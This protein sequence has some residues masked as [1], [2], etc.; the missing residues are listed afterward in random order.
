MRLICKNV[1]SQVQWLRW[2]S[3]RFDEIKIIKN[4]NIKDNDFFISL[5]TSPYIQAS[6][7][8]KKK[9]YSTLVTLTQSKKPNQNTKCE[10]FPRQR[11]TGIQ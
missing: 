2:K 5:I 1:Q 11:V 8:R 4:I 7:L 3:K 9:L 6:F 10:H